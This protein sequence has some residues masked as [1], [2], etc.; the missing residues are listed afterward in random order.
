MEDEVER[1][2]EWYRPGGIFLDQAPVSI[3]SNA[4]IAAVVDHIRARG[5]SLAINP[6]QP[7]ID[8]EDA[9]IADHVVNFEG[10]QSTY[11]RT[12]FPD[13]VLDVSPA[14]F[15]HLI[16]EVGDARTMRYVATM[17]SRANAG[18]A[19]ITDGTMP[20]PWGRLPPYWREEQA[21]LAKSGCLA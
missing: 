13:W 21:L 9:A 10:P 4:A 16:Y 11:L 6:G 20:N 14:K 12:R 2:R 7:D 15:W 5:L 18:I 17:A 1:Y 8:P 3:S 19:F